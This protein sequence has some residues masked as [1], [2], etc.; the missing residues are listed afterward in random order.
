[1]K[2]GRDRV[3]WR[4]ILYNDRS[5]SSL[6]IMEI[7]EFLKSHLPS[8]EVE[9]RE[10]PFVHYRG[11]YHPES[12]ARRLA[13][14]RIVDVV[15]GRLNRD[16]LMPEV[17][18]ELRR[19]LDPSLKCHG[20]LYDGYELMA[21][22][23]DLIPVEER[24]RGTLHVVFTGRLVGTKELGEDRVHARVVILGN[25][26]IVSTTGAVEA[27]VRPREYYLASMLSR[28]PLVQQVT[29]SAWRASGGWDWL[30]HDDPRLTEVMKGYALQALFYYF[31]GEAFCENP[32]CR[33]YNAHYQSELIRSQLL[34]GKLCEKH[35]GMLRTLL[36]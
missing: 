28:N 4:A 19:V 24:K 18:Y 14:I 29:V 13:S 33:L 32:D 20:V 7:A 34:S 8:I 35:E 2:T 31:L 21:L 5:S 11:R 1:L 26:S 12:L 30:E 15:S 9:V 23:A 27:P 22:I 6:R 25:P 16:P 17:E 3:A 36:R 10:D